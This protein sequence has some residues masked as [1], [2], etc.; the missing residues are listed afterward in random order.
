MAQRYRITREFQEMDQSEQTISLEE[1]KSYFITK[2]EFTYSSVFTV[3]GETSMT[4]EGEFF[5]WSYGDVSIPFRYF[6]GDIYVSGTNEAV[7]PKMLEV[8]S[9]L[10]A[11]VVEG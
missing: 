6:Q 11:D 10:R 9:E 3:K 5:M 1:T 2:P 4:I 8:A 7:I